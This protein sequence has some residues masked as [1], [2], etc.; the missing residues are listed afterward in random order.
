MPSLLKSSA[1][2]RPSMNTSVSSGNCGACA[3]DGVRTRQAPR[4]AACASR[5]RTVR[6]AHQRTPQ[7][8]HTAQAAH[9]PRAASTHAGTHVCA[10]ALLQQQVLGHHE[11][12]A[13]AAQQ[14]EQA[15]ALRGQVG[16][17]LPQAALA[18]RPLLEAARERGSC[19]AWQRT[20]ARGQRAVS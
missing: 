12:V 9:A 15:L 11:Q 3:G 18:K 1:W 8:Q 20:R 17:D 2:K 10:Y 4:G 6:S 16:P 19:A 13:G 5:P 7:A 14:R